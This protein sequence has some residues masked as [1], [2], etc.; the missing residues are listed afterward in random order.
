VKR[1]SVREGGGGQRESKRVEERKQCWKHI[2]GLRERFGG[3]RRCRWMGGG[4]GSCDDDKRKKK[5]RVSL[6]RGN[7]F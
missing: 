2:G 7:A 5:K 1:E 4:V 6:E 3:G